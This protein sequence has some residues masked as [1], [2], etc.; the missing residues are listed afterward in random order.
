MTWHIFEGGVR[1]VAQPTV[2]RGQCYLADPFLLFGRRLFAIWPTLPLQSLHRVL[3]SSLIGSTPPGIHSHVY[4]HV[5]LLVEHYNLGSATHMPVTYQDGML[6]QEE[7]TG[8]AI[9]VLQHGIST[10]SSNR[11]TQGFR[12]TCLANYNFYR[13]G[14]GYGGLPCL[15]LPTAASN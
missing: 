3:I 8:S 11:M 14:L 9:A 12:P 15:P 1:L 6:I 13:E 5:Q 10:V 4:L 7:V 2:W